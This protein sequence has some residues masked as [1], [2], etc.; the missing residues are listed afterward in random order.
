MAEPT[1]V[2]VGRVSGYFAKPSVAMVDI[3]PGGSLRVGETI[4]VKGHTT[5]FQQVVESM[6]INHQPVTEAAAGQSV[7]LQVKERVRQ[8]D[9]VLKVG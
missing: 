4:C 3:G 7:G 9:A 1:M 8:H 2:E 6:Q 5:N